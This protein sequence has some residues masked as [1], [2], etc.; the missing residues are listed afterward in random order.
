[1]L[2]ADPDL[3]VRVRQRKRTQFAE[4]RGALFGIIG[5]GAGLDVV[6]PAP[7]RVRRIARQQHGPVRGAREIRGAAGRMAR[8]P[9]R[10]ERAVAEYVDEPVEAPCCIRSELPL[11]E[12]LV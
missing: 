9:D 10:P 3:Q 12:W 1:M 8:H 2:M 5:I 7:A 4:A 11:A 6:L